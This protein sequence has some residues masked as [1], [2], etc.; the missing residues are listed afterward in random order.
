MPEPILLIEVLS[1]G[2]VNETWDNVRAYSTIP[3]VHEILVVHSTRVM[4]ERLRRAADGAWPGDPDIVEAGGALRL[5]SID[6]AWP[7]AEVYARTHL[8]GDVR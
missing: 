1:P 7:L 3:S 8:A 2:S 6:A 5:A 4:A